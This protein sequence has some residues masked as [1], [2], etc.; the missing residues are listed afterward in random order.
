[1]TLLHEAYSAFMPAD[2]FAFAFEPEF[3]QAAD[4]FGLLSAISTRRRKASE[5]V[6]S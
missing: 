6:V 3:D 4:G 5:R 2:S 1:M